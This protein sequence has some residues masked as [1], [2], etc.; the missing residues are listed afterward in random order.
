LCLSETGCIHCLSPLI[1]AFVLSL[2][3]T[4]FVLGYS[5]FHCFPEVRDVRSN[6]ASGSSTTG[7]LQSECV[8]GI[9]ISVMLQPGDFTPAAS[10]L[11][12][13]RCWC[14]HRVAAHYQAVSPELRRII[15]VTRFC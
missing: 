4:A 8:G 7:W 12:P 6:S 2:Y 5:G 3:S 15:A 13:R 14:F 10:A 1:A 11:E 9:I